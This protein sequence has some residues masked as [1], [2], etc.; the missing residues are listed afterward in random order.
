MSEI[1]HNEIVYRPGTV[2]D[3]YAVFLLF[4]ESFADL[5]SPFWSD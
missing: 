4:E 2:A 3:S 1:N 5:I